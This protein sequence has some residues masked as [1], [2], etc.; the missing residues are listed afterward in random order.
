M[1]KRDGV[2][3]WWVAL[4]PGDPRT[5]DLLFYVDVPSSYQ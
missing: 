2:M 4:R 1:E 5:A 3:T